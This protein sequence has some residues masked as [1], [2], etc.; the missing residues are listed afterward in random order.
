MRRI[1]FAVVLACAFVP[2][3]APAG[4]VASASSVSASASASASASSA[5]SSAPALADAVVVQ[6]RPFGHAIG[7]V[8]TQR[9]LLAVRGRPARVAS[10]PAPGRLGA[11]LERRDAREETD[12]A[13]RRWLV[14]DY[15][16]LTAP[17]ALATI[18]VP[19]WQL[20]LAD[21]APALHVPAAPFGVAP[22]APPA[23]PGTAAWSL[24]PDRGAPPRDVA[25]LRRRLAVEAA[26]LAAVLLG[27][28]GWA[29]WRAARDAAVLP[30]ARAWRELRPLADGSAAAHAVL[31]RAFDRAAGEAT[32][33]STL[34]RLFEAAP[35]LAALR[36][37]IERFYVQSAARFFGTPAPAEAVSIHDLARALR[38][39]ER[40][41][42]R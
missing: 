38:R 16:L 28:A 29:T 35:Q 7:D 11:W 21:G 4:E 31:H 13:G 9:V 41:T 24:R 40:R 3:T 8:L 18:R 34:P 36:A 42:A 25:A 15:Q 12:D 20:D 19:A 5:S 6:P 39:V 10:M 23:Q 2:G 32:R 33:P 37:P 22:L 14:V 17:A 30:F 27:W 1:G 26:A